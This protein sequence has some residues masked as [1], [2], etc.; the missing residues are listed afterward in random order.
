MIDKVE[1]CINKIPLIYPESRLK[2]LWDIV[3]MC[4]RFYFIFVIPLD[5]SWDH[6]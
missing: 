4:V 5:L 2:V 6:H 1:I 3:I